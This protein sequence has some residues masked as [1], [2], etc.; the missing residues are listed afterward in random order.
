MKSTD[1]QV[2]LDR[3][4]EFAVQVNEQIESRATRL[5]LSRVCVAAHNQSAVS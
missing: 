3:Y 2:K 1:L 4:G 5:E